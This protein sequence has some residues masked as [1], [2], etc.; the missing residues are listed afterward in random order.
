MAR[1]LYAIVIDCDGASERIDSVLG[2]LADTLRARE[3]VEVVSITLHGDTPLP[4]DDRRQ[5]R[6]R[7]Q[8]TI[9]LEDA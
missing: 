9:R 1:H 8:P 6:T 2:R 3:W 5:D 4:D 7:T